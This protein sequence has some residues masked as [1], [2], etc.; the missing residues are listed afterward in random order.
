MNIEFAT[1]HLCQ[2]ILRKLDPGA[3]GAVIEIGLGSGDY[4]FQW[5]APL[6]YR[7]IAVEPLP[8]E[9]LK[10]AVKHHQ[11]ELAACAASDQN[12]EAPIFHG[13]LQGF[14]VPDISSLRSDWWGVS[15]H[16]TTVRTITLPSL[17]EEFKVGKVTFLKLD[18]EG[19][20]PVIISTMPGVPVE[21]MPSLVAIEY[22]GG[23]G[24]K[25][26]QTG[27]WTAACMKGLTDSL[28]LMRKLGYMATIVL[29]TTKMLPQAHT[30]DAAFDLDHIL[31]ATYTGGN[32]LV[33]R[34]ANLAANLPAFLAESKPQMWKSGVKFHV[35]R[36]LAP[37]KYMVTKLKM[38]LLGS[39]EKNSGVA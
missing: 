15:K 5:A 29:D 8:T 23:G 17:L 38:R 19:S 35:S 27:G 37:A 16:S 30:D 2:R 34:D 4:S 13:D 24:N 12:G 26:S 7:C 18:V 20:E 11:V 33:C 6:G 36:W 14:A 25:A 32:V 1:D 31:E 39:R 10:Q 21:A 22:G 3:Q 9:Q 28:E